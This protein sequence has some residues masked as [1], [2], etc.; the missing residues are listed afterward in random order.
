M[1]EDREIVSEFFEVG[2]HLVDIAFSRYN[3]LIKTKVAK[4]YE[5]ESNGIV[6]LKLPKYSVINSN[7]KL[8]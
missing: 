3:D 6:Q 5:Y 2:K 7:N 8:I 4:G 1:N